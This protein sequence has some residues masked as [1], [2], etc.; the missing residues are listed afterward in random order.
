MKID[1]RLTW[2]KVEARLATE[3][4][5][6]LRRNLETVLAHMKS[7][8]AGD[9]EGLMKTVAPEPAYHQYSGGPDDGPKGREAVRQFYQSFI[10]A[11]CWRLCMDVERLVVDRDCVI[12]EGP[13]AIAYPGKVLNAMGHAV[14]DPEAYY[15]YQ[16]RMLIVWPMDENGL[17]IGEDSY[18]SGDGFEGIA[19]RKLDP[20]DLPRQPVA[21]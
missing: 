8:A 6:V 9:L 16:T 10:E 15:L 11:D 2:K 17:V 3:T 5:P 19:G 18:V 14:D 21:A 13:M 7:E 12:T 20:A 4:D 1:Q